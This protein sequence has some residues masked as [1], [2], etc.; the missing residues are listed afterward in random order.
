MKEFVS[1]NGLNMVAGE[2]YNWQVCPVYHDKPEPFVYVIHMGGLALMYQ[3]LYDPKTE[4]LSLCNTAYSSD[5]VFKFYC[6]NIWEAEIVVHAFI[7]GN[8]ID[9]KETIYHKKY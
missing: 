3:A 6:T 2:V 1:S 4:M 9:M 7:K 5:E 8:E